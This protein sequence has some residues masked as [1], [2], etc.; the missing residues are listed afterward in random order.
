MS[1]P[2]MRFGG[3][4]F[5]HNPKELAVVKSKTVNEYTPIG[6]LPIMQ[7]IRDN[8][9]I[10]KGTGELYGEECFEMYAELLRVQKKNVAQKLCIP[11]M[12]VYTA[13]LTK[14][15]AK[16]NTREKLIVI[17]F[18][19]CTGTQRKASE[20][21]Q[22]NYTVS[23]NN[24]TLWDIS[25]RCDVPIETLIKLN[26]DIRNILNIPDGKRVRVR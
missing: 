21:T 7:S 19:F 3:I 18:E 9:V 22:D 17:E 23:L 6:S 8:T 16:A 2:L 11:E 25:Y 15:S 4:T 12:G 1:Y 24:E 10:I 20:I 5:R 26:T 14:L 13:V